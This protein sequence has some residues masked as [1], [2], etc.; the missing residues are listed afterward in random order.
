[1]IGA[2]IGAGATL[3]GSA[4]NLSN[5]RRQ[6]NVQREFAQKGIQWRAADAAKAGISKLY[7]LGA[8]T[9]S[10]SPVSVG[11]ATAGLAEAGQNIGRAVDATAN[12]LAR[13]GKFATEMA[14]TQLE[15]LRLDNDIKRAEL[16][17]KASL[18]NQPGQPPALLDDET[19]P[20]LPGQGNSKVQLR[21]D[22]GPAGYVPQ[23][24]F[25]VS[26]EID[27]Y[28]TKHG[29]SPE[30]P[31]Q[32]GESQESQPLAAFQWFMRNKLMP[33]LSDSYKTFPYPPPEGSYWQFNPVLG[34]Y[35][36]KSGNQPSWETVMK[37]LR[38]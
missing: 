8:N 31:Q 6:E 30:V 35:V 24:S 25:G 17:S 12:P 15:G 34:E 2:L 20:I 19:V 27:M 3:A 37:G 26:P 28:R 14:T 18:S 16:L 1:M 38:R 36:L 32:L 7:A 13:G 33:A 10:Y 5:A 21:K 29:Y 4:L 23:K 11:G 22:I 9:A